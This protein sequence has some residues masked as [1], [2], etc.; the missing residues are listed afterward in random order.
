LVVARDAGD[1]LLHALGTVFKAEVLQQLGRLD[2]ALLMLS[3]ISIVLLE[4]PPDVYAHYECVLACGLAAL[5]Y[6]A[7]G[8]AHYQ[9]SRRIHEGLHTVPGMMELSRCWKVA[10]SNGAS[11]IHADEVARMPEQSAMQQVL[12]STAALLLHARRAELLSR[13]LVHLLDQTAC[14]QWAAVIR[15]SEPGNCE[16]LA[17]CGDP[18]PTVPPAHATKRIPIGV[19]R[20]RNVEL[21][22]E[23]P[24][25][26]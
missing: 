5:G 10:T 19:A 1:H 3:E 22:I 24:Q 2:E 16:L 13:E 18:L 17:A 9:R 21:L 15:G 7:A 11:P 25:L 6:R 4:R 23:P 8:E 14:V 20:E 12:Q 26:L